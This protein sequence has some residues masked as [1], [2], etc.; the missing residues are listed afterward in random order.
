[1]ACALAILRYDANVN[2]PQQ[3]QHNSY[4]WDT[5]VIQLGYS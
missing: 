5:A 1:M 3:V 4:S 2:Q